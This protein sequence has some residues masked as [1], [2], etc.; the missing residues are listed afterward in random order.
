[1]VT[2]H[3]AHDEGGVFKLA[4][5]VE[6]INENCTHSDVWVSVNYVTLC[7]VHMIKAVSVNLNKT[8]HNKT[9]RWRG[10]WH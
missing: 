7:M 6:F 10:S 8:G 2:L 4:R 5:H 3:G 1:M 9:V